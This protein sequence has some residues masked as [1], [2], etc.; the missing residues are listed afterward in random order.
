MKPASFEDQFAT[1]QKIVERFERGDVPL[2][3]SLKLF[4]EGMILVKS[5]EE[6]LKQTE[7][8]LEEIERDFTQAKADEP[9]ATDPSL[10]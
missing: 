10:K 8:T 4:K 5:L 9:P 3:E 6:E 2:A 7:Q 1:L